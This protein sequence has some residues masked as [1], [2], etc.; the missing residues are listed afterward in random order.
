MNF[1]RRTWSEATPEMCADVFQNWKL[2]L[3]HVYRRY[4][5]RIEHAKQIHKPKLLR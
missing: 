5:A 4:G 2:R 1:W 3:G